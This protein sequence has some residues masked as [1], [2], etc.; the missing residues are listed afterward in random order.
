MLAR[1]TRSIRRISFSSSDNGGRGVLI[2]ESRLGFRHVPV[3]EADDGHCLLSP[4]RAAQPQ[5]VADAQL[6]MRFAALAVDLDLSAMARLLRL[7]ARPIQARHVEPD[8]EA[9]GNGSSRASIAWMLHLPATTGA[10]MRTHRV[11]TKTSSRL[12]CGVK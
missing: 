5:L 10:L 12:T 8:I 7:G 2:E 4:E 9:N 1:Y 11:L 3:G 6:A